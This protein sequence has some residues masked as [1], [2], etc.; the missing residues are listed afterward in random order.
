M[1]FSA[2]KTLCGIGFAFENLVITAQEVLLVLYGF[3]PIRHR[4]WEFCRLRHT[5]FIASDDRGF[6]CFPEG[7]KVG[8]DRAMFSIRRKSGKTAANTARDDC[9]ETTE[10]FHSPFSIFSISFSDI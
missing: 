10:E 9:E 6:K 8:V 7:R 1:R 5:R 3:N 2:S 4:Q